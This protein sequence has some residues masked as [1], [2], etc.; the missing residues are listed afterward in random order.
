MTARKLSDR[1]QEALAAFAAEVRAAFPEARVWAFGSRVRGEATEESDL[2]LCVVLEKRT[3]E[4]RGRVSDIAWEV[5]FERDVLLTTIVFS[6]EDFE[7]GPVS[8]SALVHTILAE[9]VAA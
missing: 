1:D 5:G 6:K 7:K 4:S 3:S 8:D 9:G 2:D